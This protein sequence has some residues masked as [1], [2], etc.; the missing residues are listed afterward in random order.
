MSNKTPA[1]SGGDSREGS[2][3]LTKPHLAPSRTMAAKEA[4]LQAVNV[5]ETENE[6]LRRYNTKILAELDNLKQENAQLKKELDF[7][8]HEKDD[9]TGRFSALEKDNTRLQHELDNQIRALKQEK[10]KVTSTENQL[11]DENDQFRR[12][13]EQ[14]K[15]QIFQK[16][17]EIRLVSK[18]I[19][20]MRREIDKSSRVNISDRDFEIMHELESLKNER[21]D[22]I[23]DREEL[24][25]NNSKLR[26]ELKNLEIQLDE[27]AAELKNENRRHSLLT[28]EFNSLLEENNHLKMQLRRRSQRHSIAM[29]SRDDSSVSTSASVSDGSHA[30]RSSRKYNSSLALNRE[31]SMSTISDERLPQATRKFS[32]EF[33][34]MTTTSTPRDSSSSFYAQPHQTAR[35]LAAGGKKMSRDNDKGNYDNASGS[36]PDTLPSIPGSSTGSSKTAGTWKP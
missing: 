17:N 34:N 19:D 28:K 33:S 15:S 20:L 2:L 12:Q 9:V 5:L 26:N 21:K 14:L 4:I 24:S 16:D 1:K 18:D 11:R 3:S 30:L 29:T 36:S 6:D 8:Y 22:L 25:K 32:R 13:A 10:Q 7:S 27:K 31:S 35:D 23:I